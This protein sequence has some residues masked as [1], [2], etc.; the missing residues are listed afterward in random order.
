MS[1]HGTRSYRA[2]EGDILGV[3]RQDGKW[4]FQW[5]IYFDFDFKYITLCVRRIKSTMISKPNTTETFQ[6]DLRILVQAEK[7]LFCPFS[8]IN[9]AHL[10]SL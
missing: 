10:L 6:I 4:E 2:Q 7:G 9:K 5:L 1:V 8:G 3:G